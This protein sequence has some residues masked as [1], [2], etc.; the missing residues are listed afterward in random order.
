MLAAFWVRSLS[1]TASE[2]DAKGLGRRAGLEERR[3]GIGDANER[4]LG[5][6]RWVG[7]W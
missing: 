2:A 1:T 5:A 7:G 3:F 6:N 4:N